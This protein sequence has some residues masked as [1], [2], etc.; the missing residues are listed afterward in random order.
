M[1]LQDVVPW[2]RS[3]AEYRSMF[4]L[5]DADLGKRILG[6]GDGPASFNAEVTAAGGHVISVDPVYAF[7]GF[8]IRSRIAEVYPTILEQLARHRG[9]YIWDHFP[10]VEQVANARMQAMER[11]LQDYELGRQQ[12]RY[13]EA[14]LPALPFEN[15]AFELALCSHF[16]F[17]YSTQLN[18]EAHVAGTRELCRVAREVRIYPLVSLEGMESPHLGAVV[19]RLHAEGIAARRE[20]VNYRF[21]KGAT[22][23]LVLYKA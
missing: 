17:L 23:M 13:V 20:A 6:C 1:E 15:H 5:T 22:D 10:G 19:E 21:Q 2:G 14:A 7:S 3:L 11:F 4:S 9:D 16:L 8:Q 18:L 12:G